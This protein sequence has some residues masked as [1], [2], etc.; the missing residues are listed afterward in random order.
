MVLCAAKSLAVDGDMAIGDR[1]SDELGGVVASTLSE[2]M[3]LVGFVRSC[4]KKGY[5]ANEHLQ[6]PVPF[7]ARHLSQS[8]AMPSQCCL[9]TKSCATCD[10]IAAATSF[11]ATSEA[12]CKSWMASC[13]RPSSPSHRHHRLR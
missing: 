4:P 11:C 12:S 13:A 3:A 9:S 5:G 8:P 2:A 7:I 6:A 1:A 10:H